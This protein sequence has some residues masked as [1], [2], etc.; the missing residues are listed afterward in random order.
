[1]QQVEDVVP[2]A[3]FRNASIGVPLASGG[4]KIGYLRDH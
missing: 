1:M 3:N 2:I 4:W